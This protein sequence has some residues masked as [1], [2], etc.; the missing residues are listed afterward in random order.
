MTQ[1]EN[2]TTQMNSLEATIYREQKYISK[3]GEANDLGEYDE[4]WEQYKQDAEHHLQA[5]DM[6]KNMRDQIKNN[7]N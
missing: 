7:N 5:W 3:H 2:I 4:Q 1:L 6:L